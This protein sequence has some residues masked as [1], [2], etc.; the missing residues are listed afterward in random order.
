LDL[1]DLKKEKIYYRKTAENIPF[2]NGRDRNEM[3]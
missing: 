3:K 1:G 2:Q